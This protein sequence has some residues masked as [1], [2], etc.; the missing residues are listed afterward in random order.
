M[1]IGE[2]HGPPTAAKRGHHQARQLGLDLEIER[3]IQEI[4]LREAIIAKHRGR[5]SARKQLDVD[6]LRGYRVMT[7]E[8]SV[9]EWREAHEQLKG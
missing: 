6:G 8:D 7:I 1:R 3:R 5:Q 2:R 9:R 4:G